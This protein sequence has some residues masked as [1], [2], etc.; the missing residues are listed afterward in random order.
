MFY[1]Y[2]TKNEGKYGFGVSSELLYKKLTTDLCY[3]EV[4]NE[5][6]E[7]K[8]REEYLKNL[9]IYIFQCTFWKV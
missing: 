6:S 3:F 1:T 7:A 4:F 5:K 9:S 8:H 2:L